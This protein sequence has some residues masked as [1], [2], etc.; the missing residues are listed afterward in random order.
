MKG[1]RDFA[2]VAMAAAGCLAVAVP[3][4]A[5]QV[6]ILKFASIQARGQPSYKGMENM[7][8]IVADRTHGALKLETFAD[9]AL[10]TEQ[11][12]T[13][14]VQFGTI[15]MYMGSS[16][17][18]GRFLPSLEAFSSPYVWRDVDHMM[19]VVRGPIGEEI[20]QD[21]IAKAGIRILDMGWFFGARHI[22]THDFEVRTPADLKGRKIRM[23]PTAIYVETMNAMGANVIPMDFKEVYTGLQTGIIAG[24]D[25][26]ANVYA[27]RSMWEVVN[28][29][30]LTSHIM[31]NQV[32]IINDKLFQSFPP[33]WRKILVDAAREAG[34]YQTDLTIKGD[35]AALDQLASHGVKIVKPDVAAFRAA[36]ANVH[37][38]FESKWKPGLYER[39]VNTR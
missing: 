31:Q 17:A 4:Q 7:A 33:E 10:G 22:A 13:E 20:N 29:I 16:G 21:M 26:P 24:L 6:R 19:K 3:A 5:Q 39:I 18:V 27:A 25:N 38:K 28:N 14:G 9:G 35:Q 12:S 23:Q 36:T 1:I 34:D 32:V 8:Q 30:S 2:F 37:K 15:D 11:E